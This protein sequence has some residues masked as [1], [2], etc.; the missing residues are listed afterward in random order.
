MSIFPKL[1]HVFDVIFF[2]RGNHHFL[3]Q[4]DKLIVQCI[5]RGR[6][7]INEMPWRKSV[8]RNLPYLPSITAVITERTANTKAQRWTSWPVKKIKLRDTD[9]FFYGMWQRS[10]VV[11]GIPG[12]KRTLPEGGPNS[13]L[14]MWPNAA[15]VLL[16]TW[17]NESGCFFD[18]SLRTTFNCVTPRVRGEVHIHTGREADIKTPGRLPSGPVKTVLDSPPG[19]LCE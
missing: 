15:G 1:T 14:S 2:K 16:T 6:T 3:M 4:L 9:P 7:S 17:S 8:G 18:V 13:G 5:Q 19:S 11:A 10:E 12:E